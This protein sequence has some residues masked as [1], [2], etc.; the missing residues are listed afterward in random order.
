MHNFWE[1]LVELE[2]RL[3]TVEWNLWSKYFPRWRCPWVF[4]RFSVLEGPF[5][6]SQRVHLYVLRISICKNILWNALWTCVSLSHPLS[7]LMR[8]RLMRK[9]QRLGHPLE[10]YHYSTLFFQYFA[11]KWNDL[12][13]LLWKIWV[14]VKF[15]PNFGRFILTSI[16]IRNFLWILLYDYP[17]VRKL[18]INELII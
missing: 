1:N 11:E 13:W 14:I 3:D 4:L 18:F 12:V 8:C 5:T 16:L 6:A 10:D 7:L 2:W 9:G 17:S 15:M